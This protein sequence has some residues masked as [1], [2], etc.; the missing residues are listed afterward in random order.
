VQVVKLMRGFAVKT[1]SIF[2]EEIPRRQK[3]TRAAA[4]EAGSPPARKCRISAERKALETRSLTGPN[5]MKVTGFERSREAL[6]REKALKGR[7][8]RAFLA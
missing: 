5:V 1:A 4:C 6:S 7:T 2:K 8:P 3:P